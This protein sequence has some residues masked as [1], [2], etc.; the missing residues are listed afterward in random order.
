MNQ[1][2]TAKGSTS[3][4]TGTICPKTASYKS[5]SKYMETILLIV[6]GTKFPTGVDGGKTYW[7]ALSSTTDGGKTEFTSVTVTAGTV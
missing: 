6:K 2:L 4:A 1:E 3:Y 5:V 7:T